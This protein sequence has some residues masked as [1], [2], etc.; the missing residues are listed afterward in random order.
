MPTRAAAT[1]ALLTAA[2]TAAAQPTAFTYQGRLKNGTQP[3]AGLHD[4]RFTLFNAAS[5]G[6]QIG[7]PQ[8]ID[9]LA[10]TDGVFTATIDFGPQFSTQEPRFIQIEVRADTGLGCAS[11][12]GF[13]ALSPRQPINPAPAATHAH[14]A[15]ALD[16]PD[17]SPANAVFVSNDGR[18]GIGTTTPTAWLD[19]QATNNS[20]V[21]F[22]RR[23]GGGL[24]HNL[25]IEGSGDGGLQLLDAN[26][27]VRVQFRSGNNTYFNFGNVGIG[28][29]S[30]LSTLDVRGDIRF[31]PVAQFRAVGAPENL[32]IVRGNID[33]D[34]SV[35]AGTGFTCQRTGEGFYTIRF[36]TA[37]A[38]V[39]TVT[40]Q[41]YRPN[42]GIWRIAHLEEPT[43][44][45]LTI[46]VKEEGE[47]KQ[48][49]SD[50]GFWAIGPR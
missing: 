21:L 2:T 9:N 45:T 33:G 12:T 32:R 34:G 47:L 4:F 42:G 5:G 10:V 37:F 25:F 43:P 16:A 29:S 19:I 1:L 38:G 30:P 44:S 22:G 26:G 8:C 14:A 49:D 35:T 27:T 6:T 17:G 13:V 36:N 31:G 41:A 3:A 48:T 20:N 46:R 18:V 23:N 39:P 7:A 50:F 24:A 40:L 11:P 15:F 28:T